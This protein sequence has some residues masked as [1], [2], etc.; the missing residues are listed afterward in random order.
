MRTRII[1]TLL[2]IIITPLVK[3]DDI[4]LIKNCAA[5]AANQPFI[6]KVYVT[7]V[8]LNRALDRRWPST[9]KEVIYQPKQFSWTGLKHDLNMEP[10]VIA[11]CIKAI[12]IAKEIKTFDYTH[13]YA[14]NIVV[15]S[16][17]L[18]H[19]QKIIIADHTFIKL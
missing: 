13:Y 18:K 2:L 14:H 8:V 16:W 7:R 5:E 3:A 11:E 9:I 19:K 1:I 10:K 4:D 6:G 17:A 15:P 12:R